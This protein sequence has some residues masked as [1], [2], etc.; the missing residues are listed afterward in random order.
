MLQSSWWR[1]VVTSCVSSCGGGG[2]SRVVEPRHLD[3][4]LGNDLQG[5]VWHFT[6]PISPKPI[7]SVTQ[8]PSPPNPL[9]RSP[10]LGVVPTALR[11]LRAPLDPTM[12]ESEMHSP[13]QA[14]MTKLHSIPRKHGDSN[15]LNC[16]FNRPTT[17][18]A[19]ERCWYLGTQW[20]DGDR[21][22]DAGGWA[23]TAWA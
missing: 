4:G 18:L 19:F 2:W 23:V 22:S 7:Y 9:S 16:S 11:A 12:T 20:A 1:G 8:P 15:P 6:Q 10:T 14:T 13:P 3:R 21:L 17:E 5:R